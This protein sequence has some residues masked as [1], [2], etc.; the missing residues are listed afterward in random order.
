MNKNDQSSG[1]KEWYELWQKQ[2]KEFFDS[3]EKNL[4][5]FME[6]GSAFNPENHLQ[7]IQQWM[8]LLKSQWQF[9]PLTEEQKAYASY[10][11]MMMSMCNEAC[12]RMLSEWIKRTREQ[13]P[14]HSIRELYELWLNSCHEVYQTSIRNKA[15]QDAYGDFMNAA[16][17]FWDS[18]MPK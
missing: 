10:W 1:Y 9:M 14:I 5:I 3:A 18:V 8:S 13:Q 6:Q 17:K 11:Q 7:Q 12:D 15:Y 2:S 16:F 4:K